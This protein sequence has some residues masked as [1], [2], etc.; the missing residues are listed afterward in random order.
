MKYVKGNLLEADAQALVNTVN[1]V[2]VMGKGIALQFKERFPL[3]FKIYADACKKGEMRIG[4]MLVVREHRLQGEFIIINFPTKTEW[5]KKSQYNY[6]EEG[7]KDLAKVIV[8][9]KIDNI[10]IPPLGCGNGGLRWSN[11]KSMMEK[12]LG[13]LVNVTIQIYEPND[14]VKKILQKEELRKD[15]GLTP[16]RA[17]L[18]DA[19]YTYVLR[20]E[21]ASVFAANK[22]AYFLQRSGEKMKLQ[23]VGYTYGPYA[24]AVEKV[25]YALNGKYLKG[26]EQMSAHAFEPLQMNFERYDEVKQ[27]ISRELSSEQRDRLKNLYVLID[28]FE[29]TLALEILASVDFLRHE[30]KSITEEKLYEKIQDWNDRKKNLIK[31]EYISIAIEHLDNYSIQLEFA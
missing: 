27:F 7:L 3:N 12:Y 1:T 30:N 21:D 5:Y 8:D 17:M 31:Q 20:G 15:I 24:H 29:S 18:L 23:F 6:I 11:V 13:H 4:K 26:L 14:E 25:L 19:L 22:L 2:G 10:A 28:G 9:Y 16:A